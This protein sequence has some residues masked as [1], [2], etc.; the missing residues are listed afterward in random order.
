MFPQVIKIFSKTPTWFTVIIGIG[1]LIY[2]FF[3]V[4]LSQNVQI[5]FFV[6]LIMLTGIPHGALDHL[7]QQETD[8][9]SNRKF[10]FWK[11]LIQYVVIM[12][13]YAVL[14]FWFSGISLL[15]FLLISAWHFGETDLE[16]I[17]KNV[18]IWT[19]TRLIYGFY[20]LAFIL[21]TH[22][23][24]VSPIIE[25]MIENQPSALIFW[26]FVHSNFKQIL[27]L[28]GLS[29]CTI[30]IVAQSEYLIKFDKIR[31]F[32]LCLIL[33]ISVGLPLLPAFAL[34]FGGWHALCA[35]DNI[36]GYLSKDHPKLSFQLVY[37]KSMPFT[38][39]A[40]IFLGLFLWYFNN[41]TQEVSPLPILFVFISLITLPHLII[42][43]QM[44]HQTE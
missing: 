19:A 11:F 33:L 20:V 10:S 15:I 36:H 29:L 7:I 8:K 34:Y 31:F 24:E 38:F 43:H 2:Q 22:T 26:N 16:K 21:L 18:L 9:K 35:F 14:W 39:L 3:Q 1:L 27:Y 25:K 13:V 17:P 4:Q 28:L 40:I 30:F 37:M 42:S 41:F 23:S 44:N 6:V 5:A 32:R 12:G